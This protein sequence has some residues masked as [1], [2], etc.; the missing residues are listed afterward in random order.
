MENINQH[1]F[2][3]KTIKTKFMNFMLQLRACICPTKMCIR[4][5]FAVK[6]VTKLSISSKGNRC[7]KELGKIQNIPLPVA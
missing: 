6:I 4:A 3:I 7:W 2:T 5:F 1:I